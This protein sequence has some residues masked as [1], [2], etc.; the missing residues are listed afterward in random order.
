[1]SFFFEDDFFPEFFEQNKRQKSSRP[2][3]SSSKHQF[4]LSNSEVAKIS[5]PALFELFF[6]LVPLVH[7]ELCFDRGPVGGRARERRARDMGA[8]HD[9]V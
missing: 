3:L 6:R 2:L 7:D 5:T 4:L 9:V 8:G 1:M